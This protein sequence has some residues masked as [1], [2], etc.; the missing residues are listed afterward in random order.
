M[1]RFYRQKTSTLTIKDE[2]FTFAKTHQI[3]HMGKPCIF[4]VGK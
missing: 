2:V 1:Q 4:F 3:I